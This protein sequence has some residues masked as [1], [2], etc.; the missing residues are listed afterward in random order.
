MWSNMQQRA[1]HKANCKSNDS[2]FLLILNPPYITYEKSTFIT[3]VEHTFLKVRSSRF[4]MHFAI[5][6]VKS[7]TFDL[8]KS[9]FHWINES[10][11]LIC[12]A[13]GLKDQYNVWTIAIA[14]CFMFGLSPQIVSHISVHMTSFAHFIIIFQ[15][16]C[17]TKNVCLNM[18]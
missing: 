9:M 10:R 13:E 15:K 5:Q 1:K 11:F 8:G 4:P 12:D 18:S 16:T 17:N 3:L 7:D 2:H 14:I 6:W